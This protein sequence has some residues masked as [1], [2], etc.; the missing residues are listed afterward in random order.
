M[1]LLVDHA[2]ASASEPLVHVLK[3]SR[4][5]TV[6]GE[7]TAGHMLMALPASLR[8]GWVATIPEADFIAA[9]GVRIEGAGVEPN[10]KTAQTDSYLA[11]A[12]RLEGTLPFSAAFVRGGSVQTHSS[13]RPTPSAPIVPRLPQRIASSPRPMPLRWPPCTSGLL[14][15]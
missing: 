13:G 9:D 11:V 1:Y 14:S 5:A 10:V 7:R 3:T 4:R 8:D 6:I 2:T 15:S 12:R